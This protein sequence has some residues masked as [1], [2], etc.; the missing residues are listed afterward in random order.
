MAHLFVFACLYACLFLFEH[1][2]L[3][4]NF[5]CSVGVRL[6]NIPVFCILYADSAIRTASLNDK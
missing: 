5:L 2:H 4:L 1:K 3:D 6:I